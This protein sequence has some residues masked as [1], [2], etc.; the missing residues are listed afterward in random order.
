M[1]LFLFLCD[2]LHAS[3]L[4]CCVALCCVCYYL[5]GM[6]VQLNQRDFEDGAGAA[7]DFSTAGLAS[8]ALP[9]SA[10]AKK[11]GGKQSMG[12]SGGDADG[13]KSV[14]RLSISR[15][16]FIYIQS[17]ASSVLSVRFTQSVLIMLCHITLM[18]VCLC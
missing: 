6:C 7:S 16:T 18:Y 2:Y 12:G 11:V 10:A 14:D 17:I 8:D 5:I 9:S 1:C 3:M 13:L 15:L 4:S